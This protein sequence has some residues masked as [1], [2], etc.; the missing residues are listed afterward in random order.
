MNIFKILSSHYELC[1]AF[2]ICCPSVFRACRTT[3]WP[4]LGSNERY[5]VINSLYL[6]LSSIRHRVRGD[7]HYS[8]MYAVLM[9]SWAHFKDLV[10]K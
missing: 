2:P 4:V 9:P 8:D 1:R 3:S 7:E 6:H 5:Q 10:N